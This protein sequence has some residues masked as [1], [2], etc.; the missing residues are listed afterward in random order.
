MSGD[1]PDYFDR[2]YFRLHAGKRRYLDYLLRLLRRQ[3]VLSGDVLDVGAGY[4]FYLEWLERAGYGAVGLELDPGAAEIAHKRSGARV[5]SQSADK[6]FGLKNSSFDAVTMFDVVE[7]LADYR[8]S[9]RECH[10][11]LRPGG[12]LLVTTLNARSAV[13][14]LLGREWSWHKDP[15]HVHLFSQPELA[16][17]LE[18]AGFNIEMRRTIFNFCTVGESTPFLKPFSLL[19]RVWELPELGDSI[20]IVGRRPSPSTEVDS[21]PLGGR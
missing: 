9:L 4:G 16:N 14:P 19:G 12:V 20:L 3:G 8:A 13:R 1:G 15:T 2:E 18:G 7:H 5:V 10:R 11:V 17:E 6:P 21:G